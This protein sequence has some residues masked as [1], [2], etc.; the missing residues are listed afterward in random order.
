MLM[1]KSKKFNARQTEDAKQRFS[2]RKYSF[3]A[4]S[5]LLGF[6]FMLMGAGSVSA[7][8]T[9]PAENSTELVADTTSQ[10]AANTADEGSTKNDTATTTVAATG[11][12]ENATTNNDVSQTNSADTQTAENTVTT[13]DGATDV[14]ENTESSLNTASNESSQAESTEQVNTATDK[15]TA[16]EENPSDDAAE[17]STD[18]AAATADET[19]DASTQAKPA[20]TESAAKATTASTSGRL[21]QGKSLTLSTD[22]IGYTSSTTESGGSK[23]S[24]TATISFTG[25]VGD[26]FVLKVPANISGQKM[27]V[28]Y[29][30]D[31]YTKPSIAETNVTQNKTDGYFYL[32]TI[33]K[34]SGSLT[35]NIT[36]T[37]LTSQIKTIGDNMVDSDSIGSR[38]MQ[39]I[40]SAE[41]ASGN[42][43][44]SV[45]ETFTQ[46]MKP[47]IAPELTRSPDKK[48]QSSILPNK[49][50][51]Y[52]LSLNE[53]LGINNASTASYYASNRVIRSIN[54]GTEIRI[55]VP[56]Q[57]ELNTSDTALKN[58]FDDQ[59]T[60]T[61]D[62]IGS[63]IVI[64]I[65][66]GSGNN[67][68]SY[69]AR[70]TPYYIVGKYVFD[71]NVD[72]TITA[73]SPITITQY[74][75]DEHNKTLTGNLDLTWTEHVNSEIVK[76]NVSIGGYGAW[77]NNE[78]VLKDTADKLVTY[79]F[80]NLSGYDLTDVTFTI[81][82][83]DG[84]NATGISTPKVDGTNTYSYVLTYA[85]GTSSSGSVSAGEAIKAT[86]DSPI[87][88]AVLKAD[89][90]KAGATT[91]GAG[92]AM[93]QNTKL[94]RFTV[95]GNLSDTYDDGTAVKVGDKF[96]SKISIT[97]TRVHSA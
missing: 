59:T 21:V 74:L 28:L 64:T 12:Q 20:V 92:I 87:R 88:K 17:K 22:E 13:G 50:Y 47:T 1:P 84:F 30:V 72:Q 90:W 23:S 58:A 93:D 65:P 9:T 96:N 39:M 70:E 82:V 35:Q 57:F 24:I 31:S 97:S 26:K 4:T 7:E 46:I 69:D 63:D 71:S 95:T 80:N 76:G 29:E 54:Y 75:D 79:S 14:K 60:I 86:G 15:Q 41:D 55:P 11:T 81:D 8:T 62:G 66:K 89:V 36:F 19:E 94:Q 49:D 53:M 2:I 85:D 45:S 27:S 67:V 83:P 42:D 52:S 16:A 33:L 91:D 78:L 5:V 51:T 32:T 44:G 10:Q 40:L 3:G 68:D 38:E 56:A 61:Q 6:S 73:D 48:Y 18:A 25:D 77:I 43:L 34:E 37:S